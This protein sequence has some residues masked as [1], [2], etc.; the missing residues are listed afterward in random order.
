[1]KYCVRYSRKFNYIDKVDEFR[2]SNV[3]DCCRGRTKQAYGFLWM[4]KKSYS[5]ELLKERIK[6]ILHYR[7]PT[8]WITAA[9]VAVCIAL[10]VCFLTNPKSTDFCTFPTLAPC[11][12]RGAEA[13]QNKFASKPPQKQKILLEQFHFQQV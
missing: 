12:R 1:M 4:F 2:S 11:G 5:E 7:R 9:G 8:I 3:S 13:Q 10:V 6:N